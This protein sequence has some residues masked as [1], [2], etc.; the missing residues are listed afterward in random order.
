MTY[1]PF[2]T[3]SSIKSDILKAETGAEISGTVTAHFDRT[4]ISNTDISSTNDY[5]FV[6]S[7]ASGSSFILEGGIIVD[8][9]NTSVATAIMQF[10]DETNSA[11]IGT[12]CRI[13]NK[14]DP[15]ELD[16][17]YPTTATAL[18]L[19]SDFG[20]SDITISLR[21]VS[22]TGSATYPANVTSSNG[23]NVRPV[24]KI[25]QT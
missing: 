6:L 16:P 23:V 5:Q 11:F 8:N 7:A 1:A 15:D 12:K 13:V 24:L 17:A 20:G 14:I 3:T 19:S 10:Y 21:A 4:D 18:I 25:L 22:T 9:T 2:Y